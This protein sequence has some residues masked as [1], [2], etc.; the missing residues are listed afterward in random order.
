M[1]SPEARVKIAI[2]ESERL[3]ECLNS[4]PAEAWNKPSACDRWDVVVTESYVPE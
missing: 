1:D 3:K 2:A 4:L